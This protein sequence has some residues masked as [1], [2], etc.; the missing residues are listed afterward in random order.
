M[1]ARRASGSTCTIS[2]RPRTG[3]PSAH[4]VFSDQLSAYSFFIESG[5][6]QGLEGVTRVGAVHAAGRRLGDYQITA[7]GEVPEQTVVTAVMGVRVA[8]TGSER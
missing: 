4:V 1:S 7:V 2:S 5:A 6:G 3:R 8:D